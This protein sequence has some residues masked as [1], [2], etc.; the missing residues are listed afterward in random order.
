MEQVRE[1]VQGENVSNG[2]G[3]QGRYHNR[4]TLES[5]KVAAIKPTAIAVRLRS[6]GTFSPKRLGALDKES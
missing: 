5:R 3:N 6:E 2:S 4:T 1:V